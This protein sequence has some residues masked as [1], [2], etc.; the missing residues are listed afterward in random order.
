MREDWTAFAKS[1][2]EPIA[3]PLEAIAP[4]PQLP[5]SY[6]YLNQSSRD[7]IRLSIENTGIRGKLP[8]TLGADSERSPLSRSHPLDRSTPVQFLFL[9]VPYNP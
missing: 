4:T 6:N 5:N 1:M 7:S 2:A 8:D 3:P 9:L